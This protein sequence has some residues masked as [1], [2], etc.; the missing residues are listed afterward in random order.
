[1]YFGSLIP[2]LF[3][4]DGKFIR[5]KGMTRF[6]HLI[7]NDLDGVFTTA[8]IGRRLQQ[9]GCVEPRKRKSKLAKMSED[10][11]E[12]QRSTPGSG[13]EQK[14]VKEDGHSS[15]DSKDGEGAELPIG[16]A[17]K[18]S[19]GPSAR[20]NAQT[21][22][23]AAV[24]QHADS[25]DDDVPIALHHSMRSIFQKKKSHLDN[26]SHPKEQELPLRVG[27]E[28]TGAEGAGD[29]D[30]S[31]SQSMSC[32]ED[33]GQELLEDQPKVTNTITEKYGSDGQSI[34]DS[35]AEVVPKTFQRKRLQSGNEPIVSEMDKSG[36]SDSGEDEQIVV[37]KKTYE[38]KRP[39]VEQKMKSSTW[40]DSETGAT[41]H[42]NFSLFLDMPTL[43]DIY[44]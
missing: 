12:G 1:M 8:Q 30:R 19:W 33:S 28:S 34:E 44:F 15:D 39:S 22:K 38:R 43:Q 3:F 20:K 24:V 7:V 32:G 2:Y 25:S 10:E 40:G 36:E 37:A 16:S 6:K 13:E 14:S 21:R 29:E 23:S 27:G 42:T 5:Y 11:I 18:A 4:C 41:C 9:L 31:G 17:L 35:V 26:E